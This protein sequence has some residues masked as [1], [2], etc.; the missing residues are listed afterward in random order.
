[1]GAGVRPDTAVFDL[2]GVLVDWNPRHLYRGLF[3]DEA[4]MERFLQ[5]ICTPDWNEAQDA[6]RPIAE[7][8]A[9]LQA[10]HPHEADRIAAFYDR[11]P[12][13]LKGA[14]SG[15]V[16]ILEELK[17]LATPLYA[18]TNWSAETFP[19]AEQRFGFLDLFDG[20]LVSGKIGLKKPDPAIFHRLAAEFDLTPA[21]CVFIDD[22][23][24]NIEAAAALGFH[25]LRF[26]DPPTLRLD[27]RALGFP[28]AS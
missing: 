18:L 2:G 11:W 8:V 4:E 10:A 21:H 27:L 20:V 13:M 9:L 5:E 6:G 3:D 28:L 15:T 25:A 17:A 12:E 7:A 19:I 26:E 16:T 22:A 14:I 24:R 1:M 23:V